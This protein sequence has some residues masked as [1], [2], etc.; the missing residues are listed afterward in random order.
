MR[1]LAA[2]WKTSMNGTMS[3][4]SPNL[5]RYSF[6]QEFSKSIFVLIC[7]VDAAI[8]LSASLGNILILVSLRKS[9][10]IHSPSKALF[11]S[12]ALSDLAV[13]LIV[14]PLHFGLTLAVVQDNPSLYCLFFAPT[15]AAGYTMA[16]VSTLTAVAVAVD[17]YLAFCLRIRYR[18]LVTVN[19]VVLLL[20]LVWITGILFALSWTLNRNISHIVGACAT[21]LCTATTL[22][23]YLKIF[24]GLSHQ[25]A[26]IQE[27]NQVARASQRSFFNIPVY[28]KSVKNMFLIYCVILICYVPYFLA[29]MLLFSVG[30]DSSTFLVLS[31]SYVIIILNSSLNPFVYCWRIGEIRKQ[32]LN[33]LNDIFSMCA[34]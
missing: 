7:V 5:L 8:F 34:S 11:S 19:R 13:G 27:P 15:T 12:L 23:C 30:L 22:F 33:I 21:F 29:L 18:H 32:V 1:K 16:S 17:R 6:L 10:A 24:V 9:Q 2:L 31:L 28:K 26:R 3:C 25:A 14:A 20:S 4:S